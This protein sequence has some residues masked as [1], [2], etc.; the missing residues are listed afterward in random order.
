MQPSALAVV[1]KKAGLRKAGKMLKEAGVGDKEVLRQHE[2]GI[3]WLAMLQVLPGMSLA[4]ARNIQARYPTLRS[5]VDVYRDPSK[6]IAEKERLLETIMEKNRRQPTLS[7]AV[8]RFLTT[9]NPD[10]FI[11]SGT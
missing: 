5:L 7:K 9:Y 2:I 10:D 8:Y 6:S 11:G 4:R 3:T 1:V